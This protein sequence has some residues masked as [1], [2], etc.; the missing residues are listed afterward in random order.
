MD[1]Y[2]DACDKFI[3]P[4]SKYKQIKSNTHN[5]FDRCKHTERPIKNPHIDGIDEIIYVY[6]IEHNKKYD[7]FPIECPFILVFVDNQYSPGIETN[8]F[9]NKTMISW[10]NFL[11]NVIDDFKSK[12]YN[13]N[14][15]EEMNITTISNK[16]DMT[17]NFYIKY[18]MPMIEWKLNAM[19]NKNK[20]LINKFP[21]IW[22]HPLKRKFRKNY[23]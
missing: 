17:Y 22:R 1:Y 9:N 23:I 3:K 8:F 6:I 20:N 16:R 14:H 18:N 19:I 7:H 11:D 4:Q 21:E 15:I 10:K 5:E 2:C 12:G 13:F